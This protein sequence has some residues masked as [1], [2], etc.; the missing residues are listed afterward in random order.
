MHKFFHKTSIFGHNQPHQPG[1]WIGRRLSGRMALFYIGSAIDRFSDI[2]GWERRPDHPWVPEG[3]PNWSQVRLSVPVDC[4]PCHSGSGDRA[5]CNTTL[6]PGLPPAR[7]DWCDSDSAGRVRLPAHPQVLG[8]SP[9]WYRGHRPDP[10][11]C[12]RYLLPSPHLSKKTTQATMKP[13]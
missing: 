6:T 2:C 7:V 13:A 9:N 5:A 10:E 12:C 11:D 8:D 3:F 4:Y 1:I